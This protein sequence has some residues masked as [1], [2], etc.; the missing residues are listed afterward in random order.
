MDIL[1]DLGVDCLAR[2]FHIIKYIIKLGAVEVCA[3]RVL[4]VHMGLR[5]FDRLHLRSSSG[6]QAIAVDVR[7]SQYYTFSYNI[8][9]E[10]HLYTIRKE[11][12]TILLV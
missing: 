6:R 2:R 4:L 10:Y 9:V 5:D 3:L 11:D 8:C 12:S 1:K 7:F